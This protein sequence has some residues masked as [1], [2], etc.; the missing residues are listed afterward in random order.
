MAGEIMEDIALARL[1]KKAGIRYRWV[2]GEKVV[3]TRMYRGLSD[4]WHGFSKNMSEIMRGRDAGVCVVMALKSFT[5]GWGSVVL[6]LAFWGL[7]SQDPAGAMAFWMCAA[8]S[9]AL[10]LAQ[11]A[12][13]LDLQVPVGYAVFLPAGFTLH[14]AITLN[15]CL[16]AGQRRWKD[17]VYGSS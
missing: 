14:A 13:V 3:E 2:F 15:S 4:I 11:A 7:G 10:F 1:A 9:A 8:A 17:R 16:N 6:P 5:L 12:T